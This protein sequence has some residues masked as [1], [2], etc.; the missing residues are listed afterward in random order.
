LNKT[1]IKTIILWILIIF[2]PLTLSILFTKNF[3][4]IGVSGDSMSP[5]YNSGAQILIRIT[6]PEIGDIIAFVRDDSWIYDRYFTQT[7]NF[8]KRIVAMP[9]D[10][11]EISKNNLIVT[12]NNIEVNRINLSNE[13]VYRPIRIENINGYFV[14]GDNIG[15]SNDSLLQLSKNNES[16]LVESSSIIVTGKEVFSWRP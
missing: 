7:H 9:G 6:E 11:I 8:V 5:T 4:I 16:F 15:G 12:R 10:S 1:K 14:M 3:S 13:T 2:I